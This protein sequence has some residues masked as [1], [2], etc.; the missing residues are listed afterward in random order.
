MKTYS[1]AQKKAYFKALRENW[2]KAKKELDDQKISEIQAIIRTH[3][4]NISATGFM[5]VSMQMR[6]QGLDGLPYLDAKTFHGWK[7]NG[8]KV[9]KGEHSTLSGITWIAPK[10][11]E[12][13]GKL[14]N[15]EITV[16]TSDYVF[17]KEYHLFHRSQVEAA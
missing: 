6:S 14:G 9:K 4:M 7:Q 17:P 1:K 13:T 3:G 11:G 5:F 10:T 2:L 8:F 16:E 12:V 15:E